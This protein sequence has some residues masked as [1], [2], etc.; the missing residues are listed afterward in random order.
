MAPPTPRGGHPPRPS[1]SK[2]R[3]SGAGPAGVRPA[4]ARVDGTAL[5]KQTQW[6]ARATDAERSGDSV[7]AE[8]CRQ[9]AEH[10]FRVSR[11]QD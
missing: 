2:A 1:F 8:L 5:Q 11:G 4:P 3:T 9:Y 6:L 7:E 10:W